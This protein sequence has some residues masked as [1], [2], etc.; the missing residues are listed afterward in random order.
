MHYSDFAYHDV[1]L[2]SKLIIT[3]LSFN[4]FRIKRKFKY[5]SLIWNLFCPSDS[6]TKMYSFKDIPRNFIFMSRK[7]TPI[8]NWRE[9]LRRVSFF[10]EE[11][12]Y[13]KLL[14]GYELDVFIKRHSGFRIPL[15]NSLPYMICMTPCRMK[16]GHLARLHIPLG[17]DGVY[18]KERHVRWWIG[19]LSCH[20]CRFGEG[21]KI[22]TKHPASSQTHP[23]L[24]LLRNLWLQLKQFR[25]WRR[26]EPP[27]THISV[28][29]L[30]RPQNIVSDSWQKYASHTLPS[31][32][33]RG[34]G[35]CAEARYEN[36]LKHPNGD[37]KLRLCQ[38]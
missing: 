19:A 10:V 20:I 12:Q 14:Q 3:P 8:E 2:L 28:V 22:Y 23:S 36:L 30:T 27:Q 35:K 37:N 17:W 5:I 38:I 13:C 32:H 24:L 31:H 21:S 1:N 25:S 11:R 26:L 15:L 16:Y 7:S 18:I 29:Y 9:K 33:L 34:G 4:R 6:S